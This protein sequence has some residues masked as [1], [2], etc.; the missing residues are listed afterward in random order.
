MA[1][2][3]DAGKG[4]DAVFTLEQR[5]SLPGSV[6]VPYAAEFADL[7]SNPD[8]LEGLRHETGG[9]SYPDDLDELLRVARA[10]TVFRPGLA[11]SDNQKALWPWLLFVAA[12][13]LLIDVALRR[14][15]LERLGIGSA[16]VALW[17]RLRGRGVAAPAT[18]TLDRLQSRK[19]RVSEQLASRRFEPTDRPPPPAPP[20]PSGPRP[21]APT[22]PAAQPPS[23]PPAPGE[24]DD[25]LSR[26]K[27]RKKK[28]WEERGEDPP[29]P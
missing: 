7:E 14:L 1:G 9:E 24:A 18:T 8:L 4:A 2:H 19:A 15:A 6:T 28:V 22:P 26:L 13:L 11:G 27:R 25:Y 10:G 16:L 17:G 23:Q 20:G 3:N 5:V 29:K 12:V 21:P